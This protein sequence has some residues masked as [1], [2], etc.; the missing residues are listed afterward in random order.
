[1]GKKELVRVGQLDLV[2]ELAR[3]VTRAQQKLLMT[4]VE[5]TQAPDAV[6]LAFLARELVHC[7]LPHSD[8]GD[9]P[10]WTRT[11]GD[12]TLVIGRNSVDK[13]LRLIGYPYGSI[14]RLL[15]FWMNTEAVRTSKRRLELSDTFAGFIRELGM[16]ARSGG[17][18]GS[19]RRVREQMTRLFSSAITFQRHT[20]I[21]GIERDKRV[22]MNVTAESEL[23]WDPKRPDQI[24]LWGSWI[25]LGEKF[26]AAITAAPV[27]TDLRAL[28]ALKQSPLALDLYVWASHKAYTA[29]MK[30]KSQSVPW[31]S[32]QRQF[33]GDYKQTRQFKQKAI[34]ALKKIQT[35]YPGLNLQ[36]APGGITVLA[37]S[38]PAVPTK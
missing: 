34:A 22:N 31:I 26:F 27:P 32:L 11:N 19:Y 9:V 18:R 8:P 16:D 20:E 15:L 28:R 38:L 23:W 33:G 25:E 36:D 1:M 21:N 5:I 6:E 35:V 3:P 10:V 17:P 29:A 14:P 2:Q 13:A 37:S 30:G 24:A 12:L 4:S 7:T